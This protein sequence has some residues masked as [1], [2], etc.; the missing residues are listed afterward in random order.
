MEP[1]SKSRPILLES[2]RNSTRRYVS[3]TPEPT[4]CYPIKLPKGIK[5][6]YEEVMNNISDDK[7]GDDLVE[8][9]LLQND[10]SAEGLNL[11][12]C[13]LLDSEFSAHTFCNAE[14]L[15]AT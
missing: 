3:I 14:L 13:V 10:R 9:C 2:V 12:N 4:M 8:S 5:R 7:M 6:S 1:Y 11:R 15:E